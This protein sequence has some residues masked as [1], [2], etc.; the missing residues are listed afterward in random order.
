M[1]SK[2]KAY[3]QEPFID[4]VGNKAAR[5]L[6]ANKIDIPGIWFGLGMMGLIGW[7]VAVPTIIGALFGIWLD[8]HYPVPRSYTLA[9]IIAG[10]CVGCFIAW[11]W[12]V[13]EQ[14]EMYEPEADDEDA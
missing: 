3:G 4:I 1:K 14:R 6:K 13:K 12:I 9:L 7:S 11:H 10:L 5:K 8:Q 2:K